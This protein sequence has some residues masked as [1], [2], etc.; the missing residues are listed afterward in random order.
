MSF[1]DYVGH[2]ATLLAELFLR[3][4]KPKLLAEAKFEGVVWDYIAAFQTRT[5]R[6]VNIAVE[7]KGREQPIPN[8]LTFHMGP[9]Q[10]KALDSNLP[11]LILI[12]DV[13]TS[14][15]GWNWAIKAKVITD[16]NVRGHA[17]IQLPIIKDSKVA[18]RKLL[19][20]IE[21]A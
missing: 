15:F 9:E 14:S 13:R 5:G 3:K 4:L 16:P 11:I 7:V 2:R 12:V 1:S 6:L 20:D 10:V 8:K 18:I 21:A 19:A 17:L